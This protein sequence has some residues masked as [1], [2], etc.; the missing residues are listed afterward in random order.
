MT[1][2]RIRTDR[3]GVCLP[4]P[5]P[6]RVGRS[7]ALGYFDGMHHGHRALIKRAAEEAEARGL[8][9]GVFTFSEEGMKPGEPRLMSFE[10][11]LG[12]ISLSGV[13]AI[14]CAEFPTVRELSPEAF[15]RDVLV[16]CCCVSLAVC[17]FNFR[18]GKGAAGDAAELVRLM[19]KYGGDA[20]VLDPV[21]VDGR[22]VSSSA[23][24]AALRD[25]DVEAAEVMLGRP[26]ELVTGIAHGAKIGRTINFPTINQYFTDGVI[27]PRYGVYISECELRGE[28]FYGVSNIGIRPTVG[29]DLVPRCETHLFGFSGDAYGE[30]ASV[31]FIKFLRPEIAF[32]SIAA[33]CE[34][35]ERDVEVARK[36][37]ETKNV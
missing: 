20:I 36:Y 7:V 11:R 5:T 33:L 22:T 17:G 18:F 3:N 21:T 32:E 31:R 14:F 19:R 8:E 13:F 23:I 28:H 2:V 25:G 30:C 12:S 9:S 37:F 35:I 4:K 24:R 1:L 6:E 15:V 10:E 34:Q 26:I 16:D 29:G 27:V